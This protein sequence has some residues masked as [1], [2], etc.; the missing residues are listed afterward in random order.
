MII[1]IVVAILVA[2]IVNL[3]YK[4]QKQYSFANKHV[5]VI[6]GSSGIG[7]ELVY[8]LLKENVSTISVVSR[9]IK[10]LEAVI[11]DEP[12]ELKSKI[13]VYACD[14]TKKELVKKTIET[15]IN[16]NGDIHCL[17]NCAGLAVP[18]YFIEQDVEVFEKTMSLDYFGTLYVTKEVVPHMISRG[19]K[20]YIVFVSSTLGLVS[21]SGYSTYSPAK[22]AVAALA[23]TLRSELKP[24]GIRFSVVYP[25]D[26]DTPGYEQENLTKPEETKIISGGGKAVKAIEVAKEIVKGIRGGEYHI[27]YDMATR[28]CVV[29]SPGFTPF[30]YSFFDIALA[31]ICRLVGFIAMNQNDNEVLKAFRNKSSTSNASHNTTNS[32]SSSQ[33]NQPLKKRNS[34]SPIV[35]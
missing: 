17:V 14:I 22:F 15:I 19:I 31:P 7:K 12:S 5:L 24:Y 27:A 8:Q 6:G 20:G 10:K 1:Y 28:L 35:E 13:K 23:E 11:T 34:K 33:P 30:Y 9:D 32:S 26:T 21:I 3:I 4:K 29:L 2:C 18:G 16:E 25:P